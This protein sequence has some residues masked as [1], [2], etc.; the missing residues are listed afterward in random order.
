M[1]KESKVRRSPTYAFIKFTAAEFVGRAIAASGFMVDDCALK[2]EE[3]QVSKCG[4]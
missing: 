1:L 2:V 3:R 4:A